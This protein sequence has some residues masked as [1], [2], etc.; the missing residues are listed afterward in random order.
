MHT[1]S[2]TRAL[3][4]FK[5]NGPQ[6]CPITRLPADVIS[7]IGSFLDPIQ[8][9]LLSV[10]CKSMEVLRQPAPA[11]QLYY[12][13][14]ENTLS[15]ER[16]WCRYLEWLAQDRR[17]EVCEPCMATHR[18]DTKAARRRRALCR[19]ADKQIDYYKFSNHGAT[20]LRIRKTLQYHRLRGVGEIDDAWLEQMNAPTYLMSSRKS[21]VE[22]IES[23]PKIVPDDRGNLYLVHAS[24]AFEFA[25]SLWMTDD[26]D[27]LI[28]K[29][30]V[31]MC[32][33]QQINCYNQPM[34]SCK[35]L[36]RVH[37]AFARLDGQECTGHCSDCATDF[38]VSLSP[39]CLEFEAW[40]SL[41]REVRPDQS[42]GDGVT[43]WFQLEKDSLEDER[44][45]VTGSVR[46][47]YE[48]GSVTKGNQDQGELHLR[49]A[50]ATSPSKQLTWGVAMSR[51]SIFPFNR[52]KW[53][54]PRKEV[55]RGCH[56]GHE[57]SPKI[58]VKRQA[59]WRLDR[60]GRRAS[61][62]GCACGGERKTRAL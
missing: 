12:R 24:I 40:H 42:K 45:N 28:S 26:K 37:E 29:I 49:V 35:L 5:L 14:N 8:A 20:N 48:E 4:D 10:T 55:C 15:R 16:D 59:G 27:E 57:W 2:Q 50:A 62:R 1:R 23:R 58:R 19:A 18:V 43:D 6:V 22:Y 44:N 46:R 13:E 32:A 39:G 17:Y 34:T 38:A 61:R 56:H 60:N 47:L 11:L 54:K 41:G 7:R 9:Q 33:H 53:E 3:A 52:K 21:V 36:D 30:S 51:K 25:D 31:Y